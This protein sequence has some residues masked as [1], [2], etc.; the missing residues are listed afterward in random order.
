MEGAACVHWEV[1][2]GELVCWEQGSVN[3]TPWAKCSSAL[4]LEA[5]WEHSNAHLFTCGLWLLMCWRSRA[6]LQHRSFGLQTLKHILPSSFQK[7]LVNPFLEEKIKMRNNCIY[8]LPKPN[9][10]FLLQQEWYELDVRKDWKGSEAGPSK[11][12]EIPVREGNSALF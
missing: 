5:L 8:M 12:D 3:S 6:Y 4:A 9:C 11:T 2:E 1:T 7:T 10:S